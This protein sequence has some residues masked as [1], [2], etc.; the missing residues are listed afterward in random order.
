[1]KPV[2]TRSFDSQL[3]LRADDDG[4]TV[5]GRIVPYGEPTEI[6]E[7]VDGEIKRYREQFLPG[8]FAGCVQ[9]AANK[10]N[11]SWVALCLDHRESFDAQIGHGIALTE[12]E[13]GAYAAFRLYPNRDID[14]VRAM[15][16]ESH[17]GLSVEFADVKP[18]RIING[19]VSRVAVHLKRV[20]ATPTPA[21][22]NAAILAMREEGEPLYQRPH[23]ESV[24][25]ML[26]QIKR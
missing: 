4:M 12:A 2:F 18:S 24:R 1:M 15:L 6:A 14:K 19:V 20:A 25:E 17:R 3:H 11:A 10:G 5:E 8:S 21:Y 7:V 13:D 9:Y 23:L 22:E 16:T 26:S